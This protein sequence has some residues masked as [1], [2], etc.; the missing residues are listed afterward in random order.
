MDCN[1]SRVPIVFFQDVQ[2]FMVGK[3]AEQAGIIRAGAKLVNVVSNS[4]V[5]K[6]TV[7][8]GG[9]FG[10]GNYALC[11]KAYDPALI[12]AWPSAKYAVMGA[13]QAA[14]T[15]LSLQLR[16]AKRAGKTLTKQE[17]DELHQSI[18]GRYAEQTDIRYGAARGWVD[19]II[20]PH[21]TRLWLK[22]AL[23]ILPAISH[24]SFRTGVLQV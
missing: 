9:S 21:E 8:I 15:L 4:V 6:L 10:A 18:Y 16:D 2:G 1:Q 5:P 7:V 17:T 19:A 11:G 20:R 3:Q 23:D 14:E 22:T 13:D 12:L 24:D